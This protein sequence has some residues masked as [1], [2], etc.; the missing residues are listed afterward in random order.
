MPWSK[1]SQ[2]QDDIIAESYPPQEGYLLVPQLPKLDNET[3]LVYVMSRPN[4][5]ERRK[6]IRHTWGN[7]S[8]FYQDGARQMVIF[9]TIGHSSSHPLDNQ[10]RNTNSNQTVLYNAPSSHNESSLFRDILMLDM[11]DSY[12]NLT[13]KGL[14]TMRWI[15]KHTTVN[16]LLKVDEDTIINPFTWI[17]L[18][19]A[20]IKNNISCSVIGH[21]LT[22]CYPKRTGKYN[23]TKESYPSDNFPDIV[24]GPGYFLSRDAMAAILEISDHLQ[25]RLK[26][27]DMFIHGILGSQAG[28]RILGMSRKRCFIYNRKNTK[29]QDAYAATLLWIHSTTEKQYHH[30]WSAFQE[31]LKTDISATL[32]VARDYSSYDKVT[33]LLPTKWI[34]PNNTILSQKCHPEK[35]VNLH[36]WI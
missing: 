21:P 36:M 23:V 18:T 31:Q 11:Y 16:Y 26:L 33:S 8:L 15:M 4:N 6:L 19:K 10:K 14:M 2:K 5:Y 35:N 3:L 32:L 9:F 13:L 34:L 24:T 30:A 28:V 7:N 29:L 25:E 1:T 12:D 27:E 22:G 17:R 20:Y